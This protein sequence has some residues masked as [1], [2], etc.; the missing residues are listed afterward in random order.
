MAGTLPVLSLLKLS[1][2]GF[3]ATNGEGRGG[4]APLVSR[5]PPIPGGGPGGGA[6]SWGEG[7]TTY[8]T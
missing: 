6:G 1:L 4:L 3:C 5:R 2:R 8:M 7:G